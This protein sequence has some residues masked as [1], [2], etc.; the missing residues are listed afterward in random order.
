MSPRYL[1]R[2]C[3]ALFLAFLFLTHG[4]FPQP[5]IAAEKRIKIAFQGPLSGPEA[6]LGLQQLQAV[7]YMV[8]KFNQKNAKKIKV[9]I[10]QVDDQGDP[11][12]A[13]KI[14]PVIAA[15]SSII[16]LVGPSYSGATS[17]SLPFYKEGS[18]ALISPTA[19]N[20]ALTDPTNSRYGAPI[21][22]R[23]AQTD[24]RLGAA[25][26]KLAVE[27]I[28]NPKTFLITDEQDFAN[29]EEKLIQAGLSLIGNIK[30]SA[31]SADYSS[32]VQ[33]V[34]AKN[35]TTVVL[36]G[37]YPSTS[38]LVR[39]LRV[40]GYK[41]RIVLGDGSLTPE[42]IKLVGAP[43]A[44]GLLLATSIAPPT[45]LPLEFQFDFKNTMGNEVPDLASTSLDAAKVFLDCIGKGTSTRISML[46]CVK[47]YSGK[48]ISGE[49][50][51][52]DS[53][54]D[55]KGAS[56]PRVII[57]NGKFVGVLAS[58]LNPGS[59]SVKPTTPV[60]TGFTFAKKKLNIS[61]DISKGLT[62][63]SV[64]LQLPSISSKKIYATIKGKVATLVVPLTS[65][66]YGQNL[67]FNVVSAKKSAESNAY[68]STIEIPTQNSGAELE[69]SKVPSPPKNLV[70][71]FTE[72]GHGITVE[73]DT[74]QSSRAV[75]TYLY[76]TDLEIS[77]SNQ[78]KG[79]TVGGKSAF[80]IDIPVSM[81]GKK[82]ILNLVS[83]N[84]LGESK[85]FS[86]IIFPKAESSVAGGNTVACRKASQVR[87]FDAAVCPPGWSK[88]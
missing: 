16:G 66:M 50:I 17:A 60:I 70:Y 55:I 6:E 29:L 12:I 3:T 59:S 88:T 69:A 10:V 22:H 48:S 39:Q 15:D 7:E 25:L 21:F 34:L 78:V 63:D 20:P 76:S 82:L 27:G 81:A 74:A 40:A 32:A 19:T 38:K 1:L 72:K 14:A 64:Y 56:F 30:V 58:D 36:T 54:G 52:F 26:A 24:E 23:V 45:S 46:A 79:K 33:D 31:I 84:T 85:V 49:T 53:N 83:K 4:I 9:E 43:I 71:N 57:K 51:G 77:K 80:K 47:A 86:S 61:I 75:E 73:I 42:F 37:Y 35:P 2:K 41:N 67:A 44:E 13:V 28:S 62:P 87:T 65:A 68:S 11:A 5:A 8:T 18:L